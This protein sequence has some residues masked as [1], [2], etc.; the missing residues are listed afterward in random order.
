MFKPSTARSHRSWRTAQSYTGTLLS[1]AVRQ[2][3]Q[4]LRT[5]LL[6]LHRVLLDGERL[7]YEQVRGR[8]ANSGELLQLVIHHEQ[9]AWLHPLS[10][11]IVQIDETLRTDE[12]IASEEIESL[13]DRIRQLILSPDPPEFGT[14]YHLSLQRNPDAVLAHADIVPLLTV[15][16]G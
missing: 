14:K 1:S 5:A 11:L 6:R 3:L 12:P 15:K 16:Q 4:S 7:T 13:I 10:E 9:F 2:Q 8:V